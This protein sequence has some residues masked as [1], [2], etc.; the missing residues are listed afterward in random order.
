MELI[1]TLDLDNDV[2]QGILRDLEIAN[3]LHSVGVRFAQGQ[4][5]AAFRLL[6]SNGNTVGAVEV[7]DG[8]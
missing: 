4:A 5:T 7:S 1:L 8:D 6:D 3:I 2:F